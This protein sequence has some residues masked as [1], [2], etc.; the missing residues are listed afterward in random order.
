MTTSKGSANIRELHCSS[1]SAVYR[2]VTTLCTV[3]YF[4]AAKMNIYYDMIRVMCLII[5]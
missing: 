5:N 2:I 4:M 3:D 1:V